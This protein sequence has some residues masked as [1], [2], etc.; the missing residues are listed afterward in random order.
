MMKKLNILQF[1]CPTGFYGAER[2]VLALI[3]NSDPDLVRHDLAV[4][5]EPTQGK[6]EIIRQFPDK[7]GATFEITMKGPFDLS[8]INKLCKLIKEREI[9]IIHTH[10]YKSDIIGLLA[11]KKS[12]IKCISTPHGFE[13][14][15]NF[16]LNFYVKLGCFCL[17]FFDQV[18]PLSKQLFQ[19]VLDEGVPEEKVTYIQNGVDLL[20]VDTVRTQ[21]LSEKDNK[22]K[23]IGFIGQM[24]PRKRI[25][26]ILDT[27]DR[28]W[29]EDKQVE[30][31]LLGDGNQREELENYA[32]SLESNNNIYFLGFKTDPLERLKEF[33]LFV[34]TSVSEGIPRCLMEA[35]GMAIPVAAFEIQGIDQLV[36]HEKTGL[37]ATF[38]DTETLFTHWKTLLYNKEYAEKIAE[39]GR[40]FVQEHFS[41][42]RMAREYTELFNQTLD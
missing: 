8:S 40:L 7:A 29:R 11:A 31:H 4:T 27:F 32:A 3:N 9:H 42:S 10:G 16:K 2:W 14:K 13:G 25:H 6:L 35:M 23:K 12:G 17:R 34:M 15:K 38:A 24:I 36:T 37:L 26:Y 21:P 33:D 19:E 22:I 5:I 18:V 28:L 41:A 30:L 39:D 1:I 20:E